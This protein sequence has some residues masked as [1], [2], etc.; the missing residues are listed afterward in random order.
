MPNPQGIGFILLFSKRIKP[1]IKQKNRIPL[2]QSG[3]EK[4]GNTTKNSSPTNRK[5]VKIQLPKWC[6]CACTCSVYVIV[7]VLSF[8]FAPF[9]FFFCCCCWGFF[10]FFFFANRIY[11]FYFQVNWKRT[12]VSVCTGKRKHNSTKSKMKKNNCLFLKMRFFFFG[13]LCF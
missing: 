3:M 6:V 7:Q 4:A 12:V 11:F 13:F 9:F 2:I 8:F 5:T 10:F 1:Q